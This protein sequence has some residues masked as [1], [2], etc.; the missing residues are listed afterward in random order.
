MAPNTITPSGIAVSR[1]R[2]TQATASGI[3]SLVK[4]KKANQRERNR[5]HGLN[6]ALDRLRMCVPLP[7]SSAAGTVSAT[8]SVHDDQHTTP[9]PVTTQKLSKIDTLRLAQNYILVLLETLHTGRRL[10]LEHLVA[11]L[12]SRLSQGTVNLLRTK[13]RLD[14]E[15]RRGLLLGEEDYCDSAV[16][17]ESLYSRERNPTLYCLCA[18]ASWP[19]RS[20]QQRLPYPARSVEQW[21][22]GCAY[23]QYD[24]REHDDSTYHCTPSNGY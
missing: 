24:Y 11:V 19:I 17:P 15:L 6:D 20:V 22:Y 21:S 18:G 4:R 7:M 8:P 3:L 14:R 1:K 23:C 12:A 10:N 16:Q 9:G 13:L 2:K 5:M